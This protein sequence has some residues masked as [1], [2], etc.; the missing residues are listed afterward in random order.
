[1]SAY[2]L[3]KEK[4]NFKNNIDVRAYFTNCVPFYIKIIVYILIL[5]YISDI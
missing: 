2:M 5:I 3:S 4:S 1:M